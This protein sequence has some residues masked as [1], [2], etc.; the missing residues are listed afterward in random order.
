MISISGNVFIPFSAIPL[1]IPICGLDAIVDNCD[2]FWIEVP[3]KQ[4][5]KVGYL[6]VV[7]APLGVLLET[8]SLGNRCMGLLRV[9]KSNT[10]C[11]V[12]TQS[13]AHEFQS[14]DLDGILAIRLRFLMVVSKARHMFASMTLRILALFSRICNYLEVGCLMFDVGCPIFDVMIHQF[15]KVYENRATKLNDIETDLYFGFLKYG[16]SRKAIV[17]FLGIRVLSLK[18]LDV[19]L[20]R[21][22]DGFRWKLVFASKMFVTWLD[23]KQHLG[24]FYWIISKGFLPQRGSSKL[25]SE[26]RRGLI[27]VLD[28]A[29]M[30]QI[31]MEFLGSWIVIRRQGMWCNG[32][33][34][35]MMLDLDG[36]ERAL[37][38]QFQSSFGILEPYAWFTIIGD[39]IIF[40][41]STI[42]GRGVTVPD[43]VLV[44][45]NYTFDYG[46]PA[47]LVEVMGGSVDKKKFVLS[48]LDES[49][50]NYFVSDGFENRF[51]NYLSYLVISC[52]KNG[53][54]GGG[55]KPY[56]SFW[57]VLFM[58]LGFSKSGD[59]LMKSNTVTVCDCEIVN[60]LRLHG[61]KHDRVQVTNLKMVKEMCGF[62]MELMIGM[63]FTQLDINQV[64]KAVN[65]FFK[66]NGIV[67]LRLQA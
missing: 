30:K 26:Q 33:T 65:C 18:W 61:T 36:F 55:C 19:L 44:F 49:R 59:T 31:A 24:G 63:D 25:L 58:L 6:S 50:R 37:F 5:E 54:N 27:E 22:I 3:E 57:I 60:E 47:T 15:L 29:T 42:D 41:S 39:S 11:G 14:L 56:G 28:V 7:E 16:F 17:R 8:W 32:L 12:V 48:K 52:F 35:S 4:K 67:G 21:N 1:G 45:R 20:K 53:R 51:L 10:E 23:P 64:V 66:N 13:F 46:L 2:C 40:D 62:T 34:F 9:G 38:A 43:W